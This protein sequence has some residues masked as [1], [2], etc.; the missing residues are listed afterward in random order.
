MA[1]RLSPRV[2]L[3]GACRWALNTSP[4]L[5]PA[6]TRVLAY[7]GRIHSTLGIWLVVSS[8]CGQFIYRLGTLSS[9]NSHTGFDA[10]QCPRV[11][12]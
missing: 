8:G 11:A 2:L 5:I 3:V 6:M 10:E 4:E 12:F 1:V 9:Y 7:R